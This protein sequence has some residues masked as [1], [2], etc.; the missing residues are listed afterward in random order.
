LRRLTSELLSLFYTSQATRTLTHDDLRRILSGSRARNARENITGVL[1]FMGGR[2]T[3]Y[4]E[5]PIEG[6]ERIFFLIK[7]SPL[8]EDLVVRERRTIDDRRYAE[9]S[10]AFLADCAG[11]SVSDEQS[12]DAQAGGWNERNESMARVHLLD[13]GT[14][15]SSGPKGASPMRRSATT[16]RSG[17]IAHPRVEQAH[18]GDGGVEDASGRQPHLACDP[19]LGEQ[20]RRSHQH[21]A[22]GAPASR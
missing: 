2:F 12:G 22:T 4:L 13:S 16:R 1:M 5:G 10:M 8:H 9:W 19:Y 18:Q 15:A 11:V 17:G 20:R 7:A 3:Q 6:L 21:D 14:S